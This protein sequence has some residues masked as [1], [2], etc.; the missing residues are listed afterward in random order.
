[1]GTLNIKIDDELEMQF[2]RAVLERLG[3]QKGAIS[4]AVEQAIKLWLESG[5]TG[6]ERKQKKPPA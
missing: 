4:L 2:R 5:E 6:S 3:K 1:M